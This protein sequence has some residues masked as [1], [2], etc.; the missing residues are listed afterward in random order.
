VEESRRLCVAIVSSGNA[1]CGIAADGGALCG[2]DSRVYFAD[3]VYAKI[4]R[5]PCIIV[6]K[7]LKQIVV[8]MSAEVPEVAG[9]SRERVMS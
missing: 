8:G 5:S 9:G 2:P 6:A 4:Q 7:V 1:N 3:E